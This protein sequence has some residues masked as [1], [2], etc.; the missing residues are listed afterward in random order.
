MTNNNITFKNKY[1]V[2]LSENTEQ[3]YVGE[4]INGDFI[5]ALLTEELDKGEELHL[6]IIA[7]PQDLLAYFAEQKSL[8]DLAYKAKAVYEVHK[9]ILGAVVSHQPLSFI[10]L[11]NTYSYL[12]EVFYWIQTPLSLPE[13]EKAAQQE[14][15]RFAPFQEKGTF[16]EPIKANAEKQAVFASSGYATYSIA[17]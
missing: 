13:I 17:A 16:A 10:D 6:Y 9:N 3:E 14:A 4:N 1:E 15:A 12:K 2:L 8:F 11:A 7:E 5:L